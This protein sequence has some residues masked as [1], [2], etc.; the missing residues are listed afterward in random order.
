[1]IGNR[2]ACV[3]AVSAVLG[4]FSACSDT[5]STASADTVAATDSAAP[6]TTAEPAATTTIVLPPPTTTPA[7]VAPTTAP[8]AP[9]APPAFLRGNGLSTFDFGTPIATVRSGITLA[10]VSEATREFPD[11]DDVYFFAYRLSR[12]V[13]WSDG[14]PGTLCAYFGGLG[15]DDL[16]LVGWDYVAG[17]GMGLLYSAE[18]ATANILV[19]AVPAIG[20]IEGGCYIQ[21]EIVLN[22]MRLYLNT[23]SSEWFGE[24]AADGTWTPTAPEPAGATIEFMTAGER[25]TGEGADC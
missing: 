3:V 20:P 8:A 11:H 7:T 5:K 12:T 4:I 23:N 24:Y 17:A 19:S 2:T 9:A 16:V 21:T 25:I 14:G 15:P 13:C 18:G 10:V 1:M 6:T 22:G